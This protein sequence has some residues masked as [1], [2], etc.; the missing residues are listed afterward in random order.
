MKLVINIPHHLASSFIESKGSKSLAA[1]AIEA[2]KNYSTN[3]P[4][5]EFPTEGKEHHD[6]NCNKRIQPHP[7]THSDSQ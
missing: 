2:M 7:D 1:W 4:T 6:Y 3:I 5:K